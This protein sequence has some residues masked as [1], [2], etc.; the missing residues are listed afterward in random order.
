MFTWFR[1]VCST[2]GSIAGSMYITLRTAARTFRRR[3]FTTTFAYPENPVP[4]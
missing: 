4:V 3:P 1:N 2:V